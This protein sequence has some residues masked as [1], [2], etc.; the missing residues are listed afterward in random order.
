MNMVRAATAEL[1]GTFL[2]VLVGTAVAA[3]AILGRSTA[4]P[5]YDSLAIAV[6][7][8]LVL[9]A[10]VGALGHTSGCHVNPAVTVGLASIGRFPWRYVPAY[11]GAQLVGAVLASLALWGAYGSRARSEAGLGAPA[12]NAGAGTLQVFAMEALIGFLLVFVVVAVTTDSRV[13]A[14]PAAVCIGFALAAGVLVAGPVSGG[15]ANPVRALGPM[16][17][18]LRF[19]SVLAYCLAP[20][21][22][23]VIAAVVY[24]RLIGPIS[25]P[26]DE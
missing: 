20:I 23:G 22:G 3:A 26:D 17:V 19:P 6:A 2:L 16:I 8:G 4:G 1:V 24:Q 15:A 18:D 9:V 5:A 21:L 10:L 7:F 11:L 13:G 12:P 14:A 25:A